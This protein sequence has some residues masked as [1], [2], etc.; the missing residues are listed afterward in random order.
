[1]NLPSVFEELEAFAIVVPDDKRLEKYFAVFH[2]E[3][4]QRDFNKDTYR[5]QDEL[6]DNTTLNKIHVPLTL[7]QC[8]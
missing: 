4:C 8:G 7:L 2:F 1:M 5:E 6:G 3:A